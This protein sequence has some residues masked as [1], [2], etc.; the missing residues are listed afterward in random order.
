MNALTYQKANSKN[1]VSFQM[2][3]SRLHE[4]LLTIGIPPN[5]YGYRY[6]MYCLE[7]ILTDPEYLKHI[8]K[9][10]YI[11]VAR[12]FKTTPS[13]IERAIRHSINRTWMYGNLDFINRLFVNSIRSDKGVPTNTAFLARLYYYIINMDN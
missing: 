12:H 5:L 13:G 7:L 8:T 2:E 9:G 11:D 10:L 1:I 3:T 6:I 4:L